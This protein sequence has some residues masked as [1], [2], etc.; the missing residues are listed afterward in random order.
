MKQAKSNSRYYKFWNK[1]MIKAEKKHKP[2]DRSYL[3]QIERSYK[4]RMITEEE[5][6]E[7]LERDTQVR[8]G[9]YLGSNQPITITPAQIQFMYDM[10]YISAEKYNELIKDYK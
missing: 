1:M 6:N 9:R 5:M 10:G 7:L 8:T 3:V 2:I 4:M